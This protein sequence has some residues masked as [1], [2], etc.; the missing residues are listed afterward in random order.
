MDST[1]MVESVNLSWSNEA[2]RHGLVVIMVESDSV[3]DSIHAGGIV[4]EVEFVV[5]AKTV[6]VAG[7]VKWKT[8]ITGFRSPSCD[9]QLRMARSP[10]S[11]RFICTLCPSKSP[12]LSTSF[13]K[14]TSILKEGAV[15]S[16]SVFEEK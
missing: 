6:D 7:D 15:Y 13:P 10:S 16:S 8:K 9:A 14:G 3:E 2:F 5:T 12:K 11:K 1:N 4:D